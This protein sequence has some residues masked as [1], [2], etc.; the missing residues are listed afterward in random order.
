MTDRGLSSDASRNPGLIADP[1]FLAVTRPPMRW[2]VTYSALLVCGLLAIESFLLT[3]NLLWLLVYLP[4]HGIAYVA[5]LR[6]PRFFDLLALWGRTRGP[7]LLANFRYWRSSSYSP[8]ILALPDTRGRRAR[9]GRRES[10]P[11]HV[12]L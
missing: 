2:G 11:P 5:C 6:E 12:V 4:L 7:S 9:R 10:C 3:R 8:A 1:V